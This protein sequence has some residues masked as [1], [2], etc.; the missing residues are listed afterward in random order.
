MILHYIQ[1]FWYMATDILLVL[2]QILVYMITIQT[3]VLVV[4]DLLFDWS[5]DKQVNM[6][7]VSIAVVFLLGIIAINIL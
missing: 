6:N 4:G 5:K 3:G 1:N 2:G 7:I